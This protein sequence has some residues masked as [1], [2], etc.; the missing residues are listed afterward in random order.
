MKNTMK[1]KQD[2]INQ[3]ITDALSYGLS[4]EQLER[5]KSS[6]FYNLK[7]FS[8][9][10]NETL[11]DV[12]TLSNDSV[13][14]K[15]AIDKTAEGCKPSTIKEYMFVIKK[16][17]DYMNLNWHSVSSD[18]VNTYLATR[19]YRDKCSPGYI[20]CMKKYLSVFFDWLF[21]HKYISDDIARSMPKQ[22]PYQKKK[23]RLT[24]DEIEECRAKITNDKERALFELMLSTGL[25]V[26][27]IVSLNI[28]NIDF[29]QNKI[30]V[31]GEKT[32]TW[33]EAY[34]TPACKRALKKYLGN[35]VCG[36]L[37]LSRCCQRA[38]NY[39]IE[40]IAKEIG[41]KG[42]V[43]CKSTV[44]LYRKTFASIYYRKTNDLY[45]VSKLLG[46]KSVNTTIQYYLIDDTAFTKY[47]M[48]KVA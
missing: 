33:R 22:K 23:D 17:F 6:L 30:D 14:M 42:Q 5:L 41:E 24:E 25:R 13:I 48:L 7:D 20:I 36:P 29:T 46:H 12:S 2:V 8:L 4:Q 15:F 1:N 32:D 35:R 21:A 39:T 40:R 31:Y 3:I 34:I 16:F 18:D 19:R 10:A 28:E 47:K 44:H 38:S 45:M 9:T 26:G 37:F 27:E 43:H 11:P